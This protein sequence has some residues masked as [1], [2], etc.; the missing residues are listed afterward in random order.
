MSGHN[1]WST[2]KHKK[3]KTDEKRGKEFTK[4]AKEITIAVRTGGGG[5]P[6]MNS[7]LKLAV[8]K[9]KSV[10]MPNENIARAIKKGTGDME[11]DALEEIIYEGYATAGVAV[12][13]EIATDNRNRTASEVRH[14]FS[15][16]GGNLGENGCVAWMFKR[17]GTISI[18]K[19][20]L[21]LDE[22]EFMLQALDLG[23][24]DIRDDEDYLE[25]ITLPEQLMEVK[26]ALEK[27]G[28]TLEDVDIVMSP[29][30]IVEI[31]DEA[32]AAK[33]IK[34][35][36]L[37]EDHDDV[38]NVYTNMSIPDEIMAKL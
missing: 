23:A 1:K 36:D 5:D 12:M 7:K 35:V 3:A 11:G 25:I 16:Y 22:E 34:L 4:I 29:E 13:L 19:E 8:Q 30:N 14:Y 37:L 32:V 20:T 28:Y 18:A 33:V 9:A 26:E 27:E 10:N 17:V 38:Q 6:E 2:I 24:E 31:T 15:K 21:K